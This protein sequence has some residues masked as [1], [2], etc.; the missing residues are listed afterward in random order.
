MRHQQQHYIQRDVVDFN[1][2][3]DT[4]KQLKPF[5]FI[6]LFIISNNIVSIILIY[7]YVEYRYKMYV[8]LICG[9]ERH[10]N[11]SSSNKI[12]VLGCICQVIDSVY[13]RFYNR[14]CLTDCFNSI[15]VMILIMTAFDLPFIKKKLLLRLICTSVTYTIIRNK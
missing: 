13:I 11:I 14:L 15:K 8:R 4:Q 1:D 12:M 10:E 2:Q 3:G 7:S 5:L 9:K 6:R